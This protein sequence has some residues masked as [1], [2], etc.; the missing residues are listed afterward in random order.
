MTQAQIL[1]LRAEFGSDPA[2]ADARFVSKTDA[3]QRFQRDFPTLRDLPDRVGGNPFPTSFDIQVSE[4][5]RDPAALDRIAKSYDKAPGVEE[6]RYDRGWI[7]RLAAI[8]GLVRKGGYAIGALLAFAA[9]VTV[10]TTV[11][12]SVLARHEEIEIMKLVGATSLFIRAPFLLAAA[13]EG[14]IG[15]TLAVAGLYGTHRLVERAEIFRA[16]PFVSIVAGHFLPSEA[17]LTLAVGGAVLGLLA[18]LLSLRR[19]G[20]V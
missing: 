16:N 6:V 8:V 17:V 5:F 12:L 20:T 19:A 1:S 2:I 15:G 13:A 7:E 9:L 10:A 18:T 4:A 14:L 3:R 11:R